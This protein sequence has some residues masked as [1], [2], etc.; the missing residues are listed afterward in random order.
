MVICQRIPDVRF[1]R[2]NLRAIMFFFVLV[3]CSTWDNRLPEKIPPPPYVHA[4][5]VGARYVYIVGTFNGKEQ[6]KKAVKKAS[7]KTS[8]VEK[9]Y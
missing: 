7:D 4:V 1:I 5:D 3:S 8:L 9:L 2:L 6:D